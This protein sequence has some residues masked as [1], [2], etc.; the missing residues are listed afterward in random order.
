MKR[1]KQKIVSQKL[2]D[3]DRGAKGGACTARNE[4]INCTLEPTAGHLE[5]GFESVETRTIEEVHE[6]LDSDQSGGKSGCHRPSQR[7]NLN[8]RRWAK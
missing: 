5:V 1:E 7:I 3:S 8:T 4:Q 2:A 6:L